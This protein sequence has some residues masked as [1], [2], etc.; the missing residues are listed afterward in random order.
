M[1]RN[2][3]QI[4]LAMQFFKACRA[5]YHGNQEW[6]TN[7][8]CI[9]K[10][11]RMWT[12]R[13]F[14]LHSQTYD[15]T[16]AKD[17]RRT[18]AKESHWSFSVLPCRTVICG[19]VCIYYIWGYSEKLCSW[20]K[21]TTSDSQH[22]RIHAMLISEVLLISFLW[23]PPMLSDT[24][25]EDRLCTFLCNLTKEEINHASCSMKQTQCP[26][27]C[28]TRETNCSTRWSTSVSSKQWNIGML[29]V[30]G[31][32]FVA[33]DKNVI[34]GKRFCGCNKKCWI[35]NFKIWF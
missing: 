1:T 16:T 22:S 15:P 10:R 26:T 28:S 30:V 20:V 17:R 14:Q 33:M 5:G 4:S 18:P 7:F 24:M 35:W 12:I 2:Q 23:Q 27:R 31:F 34:E 19:W 21:L 11:I 13:K 8:Y 29:F 3:H 32:P 6:N 9:T 25:S